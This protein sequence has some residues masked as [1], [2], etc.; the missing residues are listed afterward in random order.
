[1]YL[2]DQTEVKSWDFDK[3]EVESLKICHLWNINYYASTRL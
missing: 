3:T 2:V 1:M